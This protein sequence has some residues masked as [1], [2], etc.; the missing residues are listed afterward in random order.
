MQTD[1]LKNLRRLRLVLAAAFAATACLPTITVHAQKADPFPPTYA[2]PAVPLLQL[3]TD[4]RARRT[5]AN[6]SMQAGKPV[7]ILNVKGAG[8][9]RHM[10]FVFGE[11]QIDDLLIE[12]AV[13][14]AAEPAAG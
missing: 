4:F 8:C 13:D 14:G 3:P 10:W 7:E 6:L 11:K 12:I 1:Q 9:V 5:T 2:D